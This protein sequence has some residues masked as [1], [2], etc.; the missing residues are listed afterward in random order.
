METLLATLLVLVAGALAAGATYFAGRKRYDRAVTDRMEAEADARRVPDLED[1]LADAQHALESERKK[2]S[3]LEVDIARISA[4]KIGGEKAAA[5][6]ISL[7]EKATTELSNAFQALS[8]EA[9]KSNNKA[10]LDL[11]KTELEKHQKHAATQLD[12]KHEAIDKLVEPIGES[13]KGVDQKIQEL[14]K[15]RASAFTGIEKQMEGLAKVESELRIETGKLANALHSTQARGRWGEMQLRRVVELAGMVNRCDFFE[16][17][18]FAGAEGGARPDMIVRLPSQREIVVDSKV[19]LDEYLRF[20]DESDEARK[21]DLLKSH[22]KALKKHIQDLGRKSYTSNLER[23]PEFVVLFLP[24]ES[25]FSAALEGDPRLLEASGKDVILATPTTLIG[26][27]RAVAY[28]WRED[29]LAE[30]SKEISDLGQ[31]LYERLIT[32][33]GH[34]EKVGDGLGRSTEAYNKLVS[35]L[36]SR[37]LVTARKFEDYGAAPDEAELKTVPE[38][39]IRPRALHAPDM[40]REALPD[41]INAPR[42]DAEP[43]SPPAEPS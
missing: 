14:E 15:V 40:L 30:N 28:G 38:I 11:A 10:F 2:V 17:E 24:G 42:V 7:I 31:Q 20:I 36:E 32:F 25:I 8:S 43:E 4:E 35:S 34:L 23:T 13:L 39:E 12:Y 22:A 16:Q 6:K 3:A 33:A 27:L 29:T 5:E 41:A 37:V 18:H 19:P 9:L 21:A 26:L 1:R